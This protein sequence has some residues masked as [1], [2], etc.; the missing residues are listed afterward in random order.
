MDV[1]TQFA[2]IILFLPLAS[3]ALQI[4]FG[5]RIGPR[6]VWISVAASFV[7]LILAVSMLFTVVLGTPMNHYPEVAGSRWGILA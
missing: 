1:R 7:T 6:G 2:L 5:R 4:F 3:F